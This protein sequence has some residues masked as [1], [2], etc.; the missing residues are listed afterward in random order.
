MSVSRASHTDTVCT[1]SHNTRGAC[2]KRRA[3]QVHLAC[4][5]LHALTLSSTI[6]RTRYHQPR[7]TPNPHATHTCPTRIRASLTHILA[8]CWGC[9]AATGDCGRSVKVNAGCRWIAGWFPSTAV[10]TVTAADLL[11]RGVCWNSR[12]CYGRTGRCAVCRCE[13]EHCARQRGGERSALLG[14]E[15]EHCGDARRWGPREEGGS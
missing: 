9:C 4:R 6:R 7:P 5:P 3:L 11:M 1:I 15:L 10:T 12:C 14:D 2:Q 13:C 8:C